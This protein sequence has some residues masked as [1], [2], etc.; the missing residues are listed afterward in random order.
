MKIR[1]L[2]AATA[3]AISTL[4]FIPQAQAETFGWVSGP[5]T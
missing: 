3:I 4:A 2:I 5:T 1:S